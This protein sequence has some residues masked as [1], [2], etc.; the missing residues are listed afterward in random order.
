M[1]TLMQHE[2]APEEVAALVAYLERLDT[3]PAP[4]PSSNDTA[5]S[6][7]RGRALFDGKGLCTGCHSGPFYTRAEPADVGTKG[8]MDPSGRF[9]VP[10][11]RGVARTA[12]YLHDGRAATLE[13]IF[14]KH[15][16]PGL[17]GVSQ[18]LSAREIA[19]LAAF[20]RSL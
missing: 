14:T 3:P 5:E 8:F 7:A 18:P 16:V 12:P 19:D 6:V 20:L 15:N 11:L 13:E 2:P 9:D 4:K 10:S 1:R 17:H